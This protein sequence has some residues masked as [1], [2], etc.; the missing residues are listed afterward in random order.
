MH[1]GA[2]DSL[3]A[4]ARRNKEQVD[5]VAL[6]EMAW[7]EDKE[8][9]DLAVL[10]GDQAGVFSDER[11]D[12]LEPAEAERVDGHDG[13]DVIRPCCTKLNHACS[14]GHQRPVRPGITSDVIDALRPAA[15]YLG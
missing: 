14:I 12:L 7:L 4:S 15:E 13:A 9:D 8:A 3:P 11:S 1:E 5:E 6:V 2:S 10:H